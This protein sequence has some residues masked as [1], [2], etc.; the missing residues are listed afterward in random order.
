MGTNEIPYLDHFIEN[1]LEKR[2][3]LR[4]ISPLS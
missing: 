2:D 3:T 1:G 4:E